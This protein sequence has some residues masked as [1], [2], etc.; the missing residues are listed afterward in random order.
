[1]AVPDYFER[2]HGTYS[3][4]RSLNATHRPVN[5]D[6]AQYGPHAN[7][8]KGPAQ[9]HMNAPVPDP[10][11]N[12]KKQVEG[13]KTPVEKAKVVNEALLHAKHD[14]AMTQKIVGVALV[15][16]KGADRAE[17]MGSLMKD[18][19]STVLGMSHDTLSLKGADL[20]TVSKASL[21][22][23]PYNAIDVR[24]ATFSPDLDLSANKYMAGA[25]VNLDN[26]TMKRV[27]LPGDANIISAKDAHVDQSVAN[28]NTLKLTLGGA[29]TGF[30]L[31]L[32]LR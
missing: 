11:A 30:K 14:P 23:L 19:S 8:L 13:A 31:C 3:N 21:Q 7:S 32:P 26:V 24:G 15:S 25:G 27:N 22:A 6:E 4:Y 12:F 18:Y 16:T 28:V 29:Q 5:V 17:I 1:M 9:H 2:Y 20:S 10:V